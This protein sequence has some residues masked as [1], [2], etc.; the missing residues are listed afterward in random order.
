MQK[1][2]RSI[3]KFKLVYADLCP[4]DELLVSAYEN[5][6]RYLIKTPDPVL[7]LEQARFEAAVQF[8]RSQI[9][10]L[11][12]KLVDAVQVILGLRNQAMRHRA[13]AAPPASQLQ[14]WSRI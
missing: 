6:R 4:T 7:P 9:P 14:R 1:D 12:A 5:L 3:E 11:A 10:G 2:L 13:L 8:A